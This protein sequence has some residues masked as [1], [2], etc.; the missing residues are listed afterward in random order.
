MPRRDTSCPQCGTVVVWTVESVS[1]VPLAMTVRCSNCGSEVPII[2]TTDW[3]TWLHSFSN[4]EDLRMVY[5]ERFMTHYNWLQHQ[6]LWGLDDSKELFMRFISRFPKDQVERMN[7]Q[8]IE[9]HNPETG[10][11]VSSMRNWL[12]KQLGQC[13]SCRKLAP[14]NSTYCPS[15]GTRQSH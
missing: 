5:N 6:V 3:E 15:C 9:E 1:T 14:L 4:G 8:I 11:I 2:Q 10:Q 7:P 12:W 13:P